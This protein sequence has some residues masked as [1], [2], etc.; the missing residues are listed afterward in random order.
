MGGW[1]RHRSRRRR[2]RRSS[3]NP[4]TRIGLYRQDA[5]CR[6]PPGI[7]PASYGC[8][9]SIRSRARRT[10]VRVDP[11]REN[12]EQFATLPRQVVVGT[13]ARCR[14][15]LHR[16]REPPRA[17]TL[18]AWRAWPA[19]RRAGALTRLY[20]YILHTCIIV[21]SNTRARQ[22]ARGLRRAH[23]LVRYILIT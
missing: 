15:E 12:R 1:R 9:H 16:R 18:A 14:G 2:H 7:V 22:A 11:L 3:V 4:Q 23:I 13:A 20:A 21:I 8:C 19:E 17:L 6:R 10:S 5:P